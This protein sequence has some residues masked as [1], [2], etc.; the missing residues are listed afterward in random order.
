MAC[1]RASAREEWIRLHRGGAIGTFYYTTF[2]TRI[3]VRKEKNTCI[4]IVL[5]VQFLMLTLLTLKT[6]VLI[7]PKYALGLLY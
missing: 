4:E 1:W 2:I 5:M 6:Y 7:I 3:I